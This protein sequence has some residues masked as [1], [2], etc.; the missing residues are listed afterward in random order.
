VITNKN[1]LHAQLAQ[2]NSNLV[3]WTAPE[4]VGFGQTMRILRGQMSER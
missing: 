1:I 4:S 3:L 2:R